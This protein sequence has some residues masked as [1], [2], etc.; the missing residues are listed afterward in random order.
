M[1]EVTLTTNV[2]IDPGQPISLVL[3][4][5]YQTFTAAER[6]SAGTLVRIGSDGKIYAGLAPPIAAPLAADPAARALLNDVAAQPWKADLWG[7]L[8]DRAEELGCK[9]SMIEDEAAHHAAYYTLKAGPF[10]RRGWPR[11]QR[12]RFLD[13]G[14]RLVRLRLQGLF[15]DFDDLPF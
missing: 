12:Q 15:G 10:D 2:A 14:K 9:R 5:H 11:K 7:I 8:A 3:D 1:A 6:I 13:Q 4:G